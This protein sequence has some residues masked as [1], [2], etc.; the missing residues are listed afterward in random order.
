M[1]NLSAA[2]VRCSEWLSG[3]PLS[4]F[5]FQ[6]TLLGNRHTP[7]PIRTALQPFR[8]IRVGGVKDA[9]F[10][11]V[12]EG[13][14]F[15]GGELPHPVHTVESAL[16]GLRHF[17]DLDQ[18][19]ID[20]TV[21]SCAA[22]IPRYRSSRNPW[23]LTGF[24]NQR[25]TSSVLYRAGRQLRQETCAGCIA[26]LLWEKTSLEGAEV[27]HTSAPKPS[28]LPSQSSI[29]NAFDCQSGRPRHPDKSR[30]FSFVLVDAA[31]GGFSCAEPTCQTELLAGR[32]SPSYDAAMQSPFTFS[33]RELLAVPLIVALCIAW[34]RDHSRLTQA[35]NDAQAWRGRAGTLER[36]IRQQG[37][38]FSWLSDYQEVYL[39]KDG[40]TIKR[41]TGDKPTAPVAAPPIPGGTGYTP[42]N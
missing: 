23:I 26:R 21:F 29:A 3:P 10:V 4:R 8:I 5:Q 39:S 12:G 41:P 22:R 9:S 33:L 1:I 31:H 20:F 37:G 34:W 27:R 13:E 24:A 15:F 6:C 16:R 25:Q 17:N 36:I 40:V 28:G 2:A 38:E 11:V 30:A 42:N 19:E 35:T 18:I 7:D 14:E 32:F